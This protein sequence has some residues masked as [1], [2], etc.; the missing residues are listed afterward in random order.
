MLV[1]SQRPVKA[2]P[3]LTDEQFK[4]YVVGTFQ[5]LIGEIKSF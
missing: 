2:F 3:H 4:Q 5:E 1:L